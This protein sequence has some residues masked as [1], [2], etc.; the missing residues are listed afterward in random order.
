[1]ADY[2]FQKLRDWG[3][4]VDEALSRVVDD[5]ELYRDCLIMFAEDEGFSTLG[6]QLDDKNL[7]GAFDTAHTIKG[8]S[9]NLGLTPIFDTISKIVEPLR[10]GKD[11]N[12]AENYA[13][14]LEEFEFFKTCI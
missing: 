4:A 11:T 3:C 8:V 14:L 2:N 12:T 9:G 10:I 7:Q 13:K 5:R 1:M 6:K